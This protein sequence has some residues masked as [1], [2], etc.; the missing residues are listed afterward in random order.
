MVKRISVVLLLVSLFSS[1]LKASQAGEW[2]KVSP[3]GGGFSI[4][5]PATPKEETKVGETF[6]AHLFSTMTDKTIYIAEYG[7]YAPSIH[8]NVAGELAANR[9]NFVKEIEGKV[10]ESKEITLD[11][12]PGLEFTAESAQVSAKCRVYLFGNRV[13]MIAAGVLS[14]RSDP[15][16]VDRYFSSFAF[17]NETAHPK[18]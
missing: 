13:F 11:G 6:T 18:P 14:G 7:D 2:V 17:A 16:N 10:L 4:M 5:M 3:L 12:R 1:S 8:L 15:E 9:D